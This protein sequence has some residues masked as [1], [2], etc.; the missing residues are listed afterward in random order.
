MYRHG[1]EL[2]VGLCVHRATDPS[3]GQLIPLWVVGVGFDR[4]L[5]KAVAFTQALAAQCRH[6]PRAKQRCN[7]PTC[8]EEP[9]SLETRWFALKLYSGTRL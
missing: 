8:A 5:F 9:R 3:V 4:E 1:P 2:E 6:R 7:P